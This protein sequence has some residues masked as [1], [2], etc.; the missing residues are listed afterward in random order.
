MGREWGLPVLVRP[1]VGSPR[2]SRDVF[3]AVVQ[4]NRRGT[5]AVVHYEPVRARRS[6]T[7]AQLGLAAVGALTTASSG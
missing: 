3:E 4:S 6:K 7:T 5:G 2:H 1:L